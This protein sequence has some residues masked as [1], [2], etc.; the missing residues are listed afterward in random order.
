MKN[1]RLATTWTVSRPS[2]NPCCQLDLHRSELWFCLFLAWGDGRFPYLWVIFVLYHSIRSSTSIQSPRSYCLLGG[3]FIYLL[4]ADKLGFAMYQVVGLNDHISLC[5]IN[6]KICVDLL[7]PLYGFVAVNWCPYGR[8]RNSVQF[9]LWPVFLWVTLWSGVSEG[10]LQRF[11]RDWKMTDPLLFPIGT[12]LASLFFF[13]AR[14]TRGY[15]PLLLLLFK[16]KI[17]A[18]VD[19]RNRKEKLGADRIEEFE[20]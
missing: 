19:D 1:E 4:S 9:S 5:P 12:L 7:F 3:L 8:V 15:S 16:G 17:I 10:G 2:L 11:S 6:Q 14:I 20:G 13:Y 18:L